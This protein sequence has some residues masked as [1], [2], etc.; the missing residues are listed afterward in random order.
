MIY[1]LTQ[2]KL[3]PE[4]I[5][6]LESIFPNEQLDPTPK[7]QVFSSIDDRQE[8]AE[9]WA[10]TL[11]PECN[12]WN[13]HDIANIAIVGG[14]TASFM[15]LQRIITKRQSFADGEISE[16]RSTTVSRA[17]VM[18]LVADTERIRDEN[19][20]FIFNFKRWLIF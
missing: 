10:N 15:M 5:N 6:A 3:S 2:H 19:D 12:Y 17:S 16:G 14:D 11:S 1:N 4:Q 7:G 8:W 9:K 13:S 20:R 18:F